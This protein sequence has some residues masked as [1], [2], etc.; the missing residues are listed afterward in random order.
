MQRKLYKKEERGLKGGPNYQVSEMMG[1]VTSTGYWPDSPDRNNDFNIIPS[2]EITMEGMDM[3]LMGMDN[4]GNTQYMTPGNNYTFPGS[5]VT[6][7]PIAK[8]G[9]MYLGHY[10]F[11]D[12]GLVRMDPGGPTKK[13]AAINKLENQQQAKTWDPNETYDYQQEPLNYNPKTGEYTNYKGEVV[14]VETKPMVIG[15]PK[16]APKKSK[17]QIEKEK[18]IKY[19]KQTKADPTLWLQEHPE[20]MLD[21][22]GNPVLRSAMQANAPEDLSKLDIQAAKEEFVKQLNNDPL[23]QSLGAA[24]LDNPVTNEAAERYAK[25]KVYG[26]DP[27]WASDKFLTGRDAPALG[28]Y[29]RPHDATLSFGVPAAATMLPIAAEAAIAAAPTIA[30]VPGAV[31]NI[32]KAPMVVG[33]YTVPGVTVGSTLGALDAGFSTN[34]FLNPNSATR[35]NINVAYNDP[36]WENILG[37]SGSALLAGTGFMGLGAGK[38]IIGKG[39][40]KVFTPSAPASPSYLKDLA[41]SLKRG[42]LPTY[43][44]VTRWQPDE[45]PAWLSASSKNLTKEQQGL[46]GSWY[47]YEPARDLGFYMQT[48]P[49]P[50]DVKILRMSD[51]QIKELENKL[52][53]HD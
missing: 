50:G 13:Q 42:K 53:G 33:G 37:A 24:S 31:G 36:T 9:G 18:A 3:P 46:T 2:N 8:Q 32:L 22:N 39:A 29:Y 52:K 17:A 20:Y 21:E 10:T 34:E 38:Q 30:S 23:Q 19:D 28:D 51:R 45:V 41:Y 1:S 5:Y 14:R 6:E 15:S 35:Q 43:K 16:G 40:N 44:N 4:L 26:E 47:T 11:K 49:G 12:G 48:R 27:M 25:Y 7:T